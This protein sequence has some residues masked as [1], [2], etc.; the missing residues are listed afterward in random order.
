MAIDQQTPNS[1]GTFSSEFN[2]T[3]W[4]DD[5][6]HLIK[7]SQGTDFNFRDSIQVNVINGAVDTR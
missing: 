2:V 5:G 4:D 6:W 1:D 3:N 7:V